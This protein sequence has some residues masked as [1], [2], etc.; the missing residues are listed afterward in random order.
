MDRHLPDDARRVLAGR[1]GAGAV[2]LD[3]ALTALGGFSLRGRAHPWL[4]T[5]AS[6]GPYS[7]MTIEPAIPLDPGREARARIE[8]DAGFLKAAGAEALAVGDKPRA[9]SLLRQAESLR[10]A[11]GEIRAMLDRASGTFV[12][13]ALTGKKGGKLR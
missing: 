13:T 3:P 7:V 8:L 5:V 1:M 2:F 4:S 10:P 12:G 6:F 11:D 9:L